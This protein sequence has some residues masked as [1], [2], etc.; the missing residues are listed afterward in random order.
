MVLQSDYYVNRLKN[1]KKVEKK[2]HLPSNTIQELNDRI[3]TVSAFL[4]CEFSRK[5]SGGLDS[6]PH[7][8]ATELRSFLLYVGPIIL[9]DS[10]PKKQ[11]INFLNL[12]VAMRLLL[13]PN[14]NDNV[15]N[16]RFLLKAFV[17]GSKKI[18]GHS[19]ISYNVHSVL[20]LPDDYIKFGPLDNVSC[21]VFENYLGTVVKNRLCGRNR[22]LEQVSNNV[23]VENLR[24]KNEN[25]PS[26]CKTS[27]KFCNF[28]IRNCETHGRDNCVMLNS[29]EIAF[30]RSFSNE[31]CHIEYFS[32][33]ENY[34]TYPVDSKYIGIY[35]LM[36][37]LVR[38]EVSTDKFHSK[39]FLAPCGDNFIACQILHSSETGNY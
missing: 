13:S 16:I 26:K 8:K 35:M 21:F 3:K 37:P 23:S 20:H 24:F 12:S 15:P 11:Y 1:S 28:L 27:R 39:M 22:I 18:Y 6:L 38:A 33:K 17:E 2:C 25:C 30:V 36:G 32:H 19:F 4:P 5:L 31:T 34:F 14:Q 29:G 10:I 9:K 7:W